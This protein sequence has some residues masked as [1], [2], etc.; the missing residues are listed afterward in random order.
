MRKLV[1]PFLLN[2]ILVISALVLVV[3]SFIS[4]NFLRKIFSYSGYYLILALF[5][6]WIITLI[7]CLRIYRPSLKLF[8]K[9]YKYGLLVSLIFTSI[10]FISV[11]SHYR[12]LSDET[13]LLATSKSMIYE[14]RIDNVTMGKWYYDRFYP[15]NREMPKRPLLFPFLTH[16]VHTVLGYRPGNAFVLN[17]LVLF[18]LF[19]LIFGLI[20]KYLG[21]ISAV[22]A[23]ILVASQP[24]ISQNATSGGFDLLAVLFWVI[25]F[26]SLEWFLK[27]PSA[28][29]FQL[30][31]VNLLMFANVRYES[32]LV[33]IIVMA[34]LLFFRYIKLEFFRRGWGII[35][36][37]TPLVFLLFLWPRLL[38]KN[39]FEAQGAAFSA[40]Y[41]A[42]N[43]IKFFKIFFDFNFFLPYA[44]IVNIIGLFSLIYFGYLFLSSRIAKEKHRMHLVIITS[45]C[46]F[47]NWALFM[48]YYSGGMI[49]HPSASR[50]FAIACVILS[51]F[52]VI[53]LN[54]IVKFNQRPAYAI[55]LTLVMF[56]LYHPLSIGDRFSL[57]Q[58]LPR[59]Y[60]FVMDFLN[61]E[62]RQGRNF[63]VIDNR[64]GQYTVHNYGAVN[65][66]YANKNEG[67]LTE[68]NNHL[69]RDIFVI[70]EIEYAT[71]QPTKETALNEK[72]TL[73]P[74]AESQNEAKYFI[75]ISKVGGGVAKIEK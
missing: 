54:R 48:S 6:M 53:L 65:F 49:D 17:F 33:F 21:D 39:E 56:M 19:F 73:E 51:L 66:D 12:V 41:F 5:L 1:T 59:Q 55:L 74:L 69:Y 36:F 10:I 7:Q 60:R 71:M 38:V 31:W 14:R 64:P 40:Y 26:M 46:I 68:L 42:R 43:S 27:E 13:N 45:A 63:L 57:A 15:I 29:R 23:V 25:S 4:S 9:T 24:I 75:R 28:I 11:K 20:K 52:A 2:A 35:Y 62:A 18:S 67:L 70:Q 58:T 44:A 30:L 50:W 61:K 47:V 8:F 16:I 72:Y 32:G 34:C 22:A 3:L 37:S